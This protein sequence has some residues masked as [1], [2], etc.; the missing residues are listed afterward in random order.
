[1][2]RFLYSLILY[3]AVPIILLRLYLRGIKAPAYRQRIGERFANSRLPASF[4]P[5]RQT[6]WIHAVSVGESIAAAPFIRELQLRFPDSQILVT[7]MTPTGS[8]RVTAIFGDRVYHCYLPYDLPGALNRFVRRINPGMLILM[9]TELWPNLIHVCSKQNV[10]L[11]LANARLS[12]KSARGY[13]RFPGLTRSM[14]LKIDYIAAQAQADFERFAELGADSHKMEITGSLKFNVNIEQE[15]ALSD[16]VLVEIK[17]SGRTVIIAASTRDGEESKVLHAFRRVLDYQPHV[18][19]LL[20]PR[21]P[22]RFDSVAN[23]CTQSGFT[24]SRRS[25]HQTVDSSTQ[26]YLGDS[27]GEMLSYYRLANIA[28]VG[29]SLVDT[30]CQNVLEPAALSLPVVVGPSQ[31]NFATICAQLEAAGGLHT[32]SD[33]NELADYLVALISDPVRQQQ[34]GAAGRALV[35]TNQQALPLLL[36]IVQREGLNG[37]E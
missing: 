4:D 33:E 34:S 36:E 26:V 23:L 30:G 21:H 14:L 13:S 3:L 6:I 20:V 25:K 1:M 8:D 12:E 7:T 15:K 32:V 18:L 29:G 16:S 27:M 5:S 10:K 11:I 24:L 28:F 17:E 22:E 35:E 19:L 9:E 37:H 2:L 31:Y